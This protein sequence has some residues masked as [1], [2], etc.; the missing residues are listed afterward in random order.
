MCHHEKWN[1]EGY[2]EGLMGTDIPLCARIV[3]VA[4]A[5]MMDKSKVEKIRKDNYI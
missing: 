1:G 5:F 2:P 4:D 3:A